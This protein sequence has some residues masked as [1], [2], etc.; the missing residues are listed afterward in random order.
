M[1]SGSE[2]GFPKLRSGS[3]SSNRDTMLNNMRIGRILSEFIGTSLGPLGMRKLILDQDRELIATNDGSMLLRRL[4]Y[5]GIAPPVAKMIIEAAM[6]QEQEFGDGGISTVL[7]SGELLSKAE[8]LIKAGFHPAVIISGYKNALRKALQIMKECSI[9]I[10]LENKRML[11]ALVRTSMKSNFPQE[12]CEYLKHLILDAAFKV[13]ELN[14]ENHSLDLDY[15]KIISMAGGSVKDSKLV[16]GVVLDKKGLDPGVPK[17]VKNARIALL[18]TPIEISEAKMVKLN[19]KTLISSPQNLRTFLEERRNIL[20]KIAEKFVSI[21]A[22]VV[23]SSERID[24]AVLY[25]LARRNVMT[26]RWAR[27]L[28]LRRISRATGA[29]ILSKPDEITERDL[30]RAELVEELK[31]GNDKMIFV[32]CSSHSKAVTII[33]RGASRIIAEE[34]EKTIKKGLHTIRSVLEDC[35]VVCGGGA[36]ELELA[37]RLRKYAYTIAGKEQIVVQKFAEALEAIPMQLAKSAG[38]DPIDTLATL[39]ALHEEGERYAGIDVLKATIGDM[40][41]REIVEPFTV[42][43]NILKTAVEAALMILKVDDVLLTG[44]QLREKKEEDETIKEIYESCRKLELKLGRELRRDYEKVALSDTW[45]W[46][47]SRR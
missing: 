47:P 1:T 42:K 37:S 29:K 28:D 32:K 2:R 23:I 12:E 14:G 26:I 11:E 19:A 46:K 25:Y 43:E 30:G 27:K 20:R 6:A 16:E 9:S 40:L 10:T 17:L 38:M 5:M 44:K 35:R 24:E 21:G 13:A 31:I 41:S 34:A 39:R 36:I 8:E 7:L 33:V 3:S 22:N 15:V 45:K 18:N 4:D